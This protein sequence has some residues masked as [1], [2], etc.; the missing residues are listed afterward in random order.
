MDI[1]S[2]TVIHTG[3][4]VKI[5]YWKLLEL[6]L[7]DSGQPFRLNLKKLDNAFHMISATEFFKNTQ[8]DEVQKLFPHQFPREQLWLIRRERCSRVPVIGLSSVGRELNIPGRNGHTA[9]SEF[10][11]LSSL[12]THTACLPIG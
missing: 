11:F 9:I 12:F 4:V 1:V 8:K 7:S 6:H 3:R 2:Q 5:R 10:L